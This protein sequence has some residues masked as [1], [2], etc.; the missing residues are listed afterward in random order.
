MKTSQ[1][2]LKRNKYPSRAL[3]QYFEQQA[4]RLERAIQ[5][6]QELIQ[7]PGATRG[8]L[9]DEA[10]EVTEQASNI[11]ILEQ[12]T[13]ELHQ[14]QAAQA[15]LAH[16][17]YGICED[18]GRAIPAARLKALPYATLCVR[19]QTLRGPQRDTTLNKRALTPA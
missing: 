2:T 19:C 1:P 15:R 3:Q 9:L 10:A 17:R 7:Q 4:R 11:G 14:V 18:C 13:R 6:Q 8:E 12:L 16:G 5:Q